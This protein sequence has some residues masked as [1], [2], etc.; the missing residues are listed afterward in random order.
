MAKLFDVK[1]YKHCFE[2]MRSSARKEESVSDAFFKSGFYAVLCFAE[3]RYEQVF[4]RFRDHEM[5][6][7]DL[8]SLVF[9]PE[10]LKRIVPRER[11]KFSTISYFSIPSL[12]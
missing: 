11:E 4:S 6:R 8:L 3:K 7:Y 1:N 9:K 2:E 5:T 10:K 12:L